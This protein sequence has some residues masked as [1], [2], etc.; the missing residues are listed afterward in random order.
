MVKI[1]LTIALR[2]KTLSGYVS[3]KMSSNT[4]AQ[5]LLATDPIGEE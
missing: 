2:A 4:D 5:T 1:L 3:A